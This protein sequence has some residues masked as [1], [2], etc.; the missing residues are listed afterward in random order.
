MDQKLLQALNNVG[1]ALESLTEAIQ[2]NQDAKSSTAEAI[3][4][5]NFGKQLESITVELKSIK[6]DTQQILKNQETIIS[7]SKEKEKEKTQTVEDAGSKEQQSAIKKGVGTILLIAG[8]VLAI[9]LAFKIVGKVDFLSVI[10]LSL[11]ITILAVAFE[12]IAQMKDLTL[13]TAA[14]A[15]ASLLMMSI[16]LALSSIALSYIK[17]VS[18]AQILTGILIGGMFA[19][20]SFSVEKMMSAFKGRSLKEIGFSALF[21]P[22]IL[23]SIS[24]AIALSSY[25]L[26]YVQ[27]IGLAQFFTATLIA[28]TFVVLSYGIR[29]LMRAFKGMGLKSVAMA[30]IFLP[31]ILPAISLAI[32]GASYALQL[33]QPIGLAQFFTAL[34][35]GVIFMVLSFGLKQIIKSFKGIDPATAVVAA[36]MIPILFTAMSVAIWA[37]SELLSNVV[38]ISFSQFLTS[39]AIA[40]TFVVLAYALSPIIKVAN[41]MNWTTLI[42]LPLL[43]TVM[44]VAIMASSHILSLMAPLSTQQMI[45]AAILGGTLGI[46]ALIMTPSIKILGKLGIG[47]LL[48][49]SLAIVILA[50]IIMVTSH[51]LAIG[52]YDVY[53]GIGWIAGVALSLTAFG[54]AAFALGALVFGPQALIFLA[55]LGA[56]LGLAGTIVGV[57]KILSAGQYDNPGMLEWA[58][59]TSLLYATFTPILLI[60][61]TAALASAV[62]SIFGP[63]PW[64]MAQDAIL[65]VANTIVQVSYILQEGNYSQG[66]TKEWA[67]G[68]AIALGAFSPVYGMLMKNAIFSLFG[69]GGV[70]PDEFTE[71]ILTVSDG[72]ITAANKF[73]NANAAFN[74]PP[75]VEWADGVGKAISAF[76][77]VY[78]VL[79]EQDGWFVDGP[80]VED[81]KNAIITISEGIVEAAKYFAENSAPFEEGKYPSAKWGEGVGAAL[82]AFAPVFKALSEDTGWFTSG[83]DVIGNMGK[84]IRAITK[85]LVESAIIFSLFNGAF[86]VYPDEEW[87]KGVGAS[88]NAFAPVFKSLSEDTGWFTSG[89]D[90]IQDMAKGVR[91]LSLSL[92]HI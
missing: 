67:E 89:D 9:G 24:I 56:V 71:A 59:A 48:K 76:S 7:L 3:K 36:F 30:A 8:A 22:L 28:V 38:P 13:K 55:G 21:L 64:K 88:L 25:A 26:S 2:S 6:S 79:A 44:S 72:I 14:I 42:K 85:S 39:I 37:S 84:G 19:I 41:K 81:M 75:P 15:S 74:N 80:S 47:E 77:P 86:G 69:G 27:P 46:I 49:G 87:G 4:S 91:V 52:D 66:P 78:K 58:K 17:P 43:F 29:G 70:G 33:V 11:A 51:I 16:A 83:D 60:L 50:G 20:V 31:I 54:I 18:P 35:I 45:Q 57:S 68:I 63:D 12:K 1:F 53:P 61:G 32:A 92:I 23:T 34:M 82:N 40:L 90:V 10:A 65:D 62:V 73:A 5:G